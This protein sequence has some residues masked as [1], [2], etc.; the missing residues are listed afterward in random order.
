MHANTCENIFYKMVHDQ[1]Y[2]DHANAVLNQV[3]AKQATQ[4]TTTKLMVAKWEGPI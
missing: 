1:I 3:V 4:L 2:H